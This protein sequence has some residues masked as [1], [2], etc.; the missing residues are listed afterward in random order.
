MPAKIIIAEPSEVIRT[1]IIAIV[2]KIPGYIAEI[3]ELAD[4][5]QLKESL[6]SQSYDLI[7][8]NP[9]FAPQSSPQQIRQES[10]NQSVKCIALRTVL[11]ENNPF[12]NFDEVISIYDSASA[13]SEKIS[14]VITAPEKDKSTGVLSDREKEIV[15]CIARGKSNKEI[16]ECLH[17]SVHTVVTH[18]RNIAAKLNIHSP[19]GITI[20]AIINKMVDI[21]KIEK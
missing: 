1:G 11:S 17:L 18:R 3:T 4:I 16:A 13:I 2:K 8:V 14:K 9:V 7:I 20:Y 6:N 12:A 19:S 10:L 5:R 15:G 21:E